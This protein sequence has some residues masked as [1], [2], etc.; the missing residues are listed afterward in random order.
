[1][2][3][4]IDYY[5]A[6]EQGSLPAA[7]VRLMFLGPGGSGKS[8]LL[9]GL[10]NTPL[11]NE[12]EST[13]LVDTQSVSYKWISATE[14]T[15]K[16]HSDKDET[17]N[18]AAK[19]HILANKLGMESEIN[20]VAPAEQIFCLP[21]NRILFLQSDMQTAGSNFSRNISEVKQDLL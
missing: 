6:L 12:A 4:L 19:A 15:W 1:M 9:A 5:A 2:W 21:E 16:L 14:F 18:L 7:Y 13:V 17:R 20:T 8:S 10:M 3:N 11:P